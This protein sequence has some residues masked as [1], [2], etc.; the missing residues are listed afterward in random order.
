M[1]G[2]LTL[3]SGQTCFVMAFP[4]NQQL[5]TLLLADDQVVTSN[6]EDNLQKAVCKLNQ[7]LTERSSTTSAQKTKLVAF[8]GQEVLEIKL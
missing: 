6:T 7:I 2:L 1:L 5:L 3:A 8:E 4:K